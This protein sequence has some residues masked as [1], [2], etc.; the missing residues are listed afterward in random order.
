MVHR[1][2]PWQPHFYR[3]LPAIHKEEGYLSAWSP[4]PS[5][6]PCITQAVD[7]ILAAAAVS[8]LS[9]SKPLIELPAACTITHDCGFLC[10]CFY[11][12][13]MLFA[14]AFLVFSLSLSFFLHAVCTLA[15]LLT[16]PLIKSLRCTTAKMSA[17]QEIAHPSRRS[18]ASIA[19]K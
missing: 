2:P 1:Q 17:S 8:F 4:L 3:V 14:F 10:V 19:C 18:L 6:L 7:V 9:P 16:Y 15:S 5:Q 13:I 12:A 11:L